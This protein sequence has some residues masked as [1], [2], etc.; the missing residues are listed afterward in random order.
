MTKQQLVEDNMNL[1][2]FVLHKKFPRFVHDEDLIQA[3]MLGLCQAA[4]TYDEN[5]GKFSV[6]AFKSIYLTIC[7]ELNNRNKHRNADIMS[8]DYTITDDEG[9]KTTLGDLIVGES[10]VEYVEMEQ[11]YN[12][13][14]N[15]DKQIIDLRRQGLTN[16]EIAEVMSRSP[17]RIEQ[18]LRRLKR[19]Y[20]QMYGGNDG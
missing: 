17:Q 2:Y 10:D 7:R 3:G 11:L 20:I 1:V 12:Q 19:H 13:A 8:L 15:I 4:K 14:S 16:I 6:Y 9:G 18:R 5:R